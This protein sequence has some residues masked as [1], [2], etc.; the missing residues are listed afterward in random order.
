MLPH[1]PSNKEQEC[2]HTPLT[3][4]KRE[5]HHTSRSIL[6]VPLWLVFGSPLD[7]CGDGVGVGWFID[8][9]A[10]KGTLKSTKVEK[11]KSAL[12]FP[13]N[14]RKRQGQYDVFSLWLVFGSPLDPCGGGGGVGWRIGALA[15][16]VNLKPA[17][18]EKTKST[19]RFPFVNGKR[20]GRLSFFR[21][22]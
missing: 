18:V 17:K 16:R 14:K 12:P 6:F 22:G 9:L 8:A 13:F 1:T 5:C 2:P 19:L 20:K 10:S 11:T 4:N 21:F 3:T 15:S 7:P